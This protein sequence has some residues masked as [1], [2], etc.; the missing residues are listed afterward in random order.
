MRHRVKVERSGPP[1]AFRGGRTS[2]GDQRPRILPIPQ[3][4]CRT[5]LGDAPSAGLFLLWLHHRQ[6]PGVALGILVAVGIY[7]V[8]RFLN[9]L[10]DEYTATAPR[11]LPKVEMPAEQRQALKDRVEAFR[12]A[13]EEGTPT[14]PLV[15][16]SDD[17]NALIEE[18]PDSRGRST[19][20]SR[21]KRSRGRSASR[22]RSS[23]LRDGQG[24]LFERR[25]RSQ[26]VAQRRRPD[27]HARLDRGQRQARH[28][29]R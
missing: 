17:L 9:R 20:R 22:S 1:P 28:P 18:K 5:S 4:H 29:R 27:R 3:V 23:A 11:E 12:K 8:Y 16:T 7:I 26:G 10:V 6:R 25:S 24:P 19:S 2:D 15:L 13:V 14:E 21:G